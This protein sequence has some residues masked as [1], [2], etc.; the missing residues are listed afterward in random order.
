MEPTAERHLA[1][2]ALR[3]NGA[4]AKSLARLMR[5][6]NAAGHRADNC[7]NICVLKFFRHRLAE[8]LRVF[9]MLQHIEL[10][11]IMRAVQARRQQEV[12]VHDGIRLHQEIFY[13]LFCHT[14]V[15][16]PSPFLSR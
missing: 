1:V 10:L 7:L 11:H 3:K 13:F 5:E 6:Q 9:R 12:A 14:H 2:H 16:S 15:I 8:L 4:R